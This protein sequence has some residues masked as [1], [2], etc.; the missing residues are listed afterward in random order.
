MRIRSANVALTRPVVWEGQT[1][2]TAIFQEP[3]EGPVIMRKFDLDGDRQ[4]EWSAQGGPYK[5]V[6][7]DPVEHDLIRRKE[8]PD[9]DLTWSAFGDNL[10]TEGLD[11]AGTHIGGRFR[12][13]A[14]TVMVTQ[15]CMPCFKLAAKFKPDDILKRFLVSGRSGFY[16]S[17]VEEG[18]GAAGD[19]H[20][21]NSRRR[22]KNFR[23][24]HQQSL[25]KTGKI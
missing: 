13:G 3:A 16:F 15:P 11:E 24:R 19:C 4:A 17:A 14:A 12:I 1:F 9:M 2:N 7:A 21:A 23:E 10:T 18:L 25:S 22:K 8:L 20:R 6:Y 5:A